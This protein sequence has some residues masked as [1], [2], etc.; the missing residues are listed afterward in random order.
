[1]DNTQS[2]IV[3]A[4]NSDLD[5]EI[6]YAEFDTKDAAIDYAKRNLD[7]LPFVDEL[8]VS[9]DA[10]GEIDDVF[11]YKTI[12]DHTMVDE[13][14]E[15]AE[16]DYWD[17][18]ET[19]Y[20]AEEDGKYVIGDTTWFESMN[21]NE[22]VEKLEENEDMVEC[23]ECFELFPKAE[24]IKVDI[25]YV[26]PTC[27]ECG[28]VSEEDIFK[29]DFPECEKMS[30][31]NDMIP[32]ESD[33]ETPSAETEDETDS[34]STPEEVVPFLVKDE[35]EAIAGYEQ[36]EEVIGDSN[37]ENKE[38]ILKVLDH[39][40]GEEEEHIEELTELTVI[41]DSE[42]SKDEIDS[43]SKD[44]VEEI[45]DPEVTEESALVEHVNEEHPAVESTQ[46]LDGTDN[47]V[48]DCKVAKVVTHSEDEKPVDC[49]GE[50]EPLNKALTEAFTHDE[51]SE[52]FRLCKE[53][54]IV[55][56]EDLNRFIREVSEG[57]NLLDK[58]R[59]YRAELG[60]D[61]KIEEKLTGAKDDVFATVSS[62]Q[63]INEAAEDETEPISVDP[64]EKPSK[65]VKMAN[66]AGLTGMDFEAAC[67]KF[68][69]NL[70]D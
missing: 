56:G 7:K 57:E 30:T 31:G 45:E 40:K 10:N 22:L 49:E 62:G 37:V 54:G 19:M 68:G 15:E 69:V 53:I 25:G 35:E 20:D 48:V 61:F 50:R 18:L 46:E 4:V 60:D 33:E 67:Q 24:C 5:D 43:I 14:K 8:H 16:D 27:A 28:T 34:I 3:Y 38:E 47:A 2:S 6:L 70:E 1:M 65:N 51:L 23:K 26:C 29:M 13:T 17:D 11:E 41:D 55:T 42:K 64:A 58:L 63:D 66:T 44:E 59:A 32:D 9:R 39:I 12:W 36:A 52:I 21:A